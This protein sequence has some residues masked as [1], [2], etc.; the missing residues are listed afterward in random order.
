VEAWELPAP[1]S[2]PASDPVAVLSLHDT[3]TG[4]PQPVAPAAA[5][6]GEGAG[7]EPIRIYACG[8]TPYD[9]THL[10]HAHTFVALDLLHRTL[11]DGG[12]RVHLVQN[13]TDVDDPLFARARATGEPWQVIAHREERRF[14]RDMGALEVLPPTVYVAASEAI[15]E[16]RQLVAALRERG[17]AYPLA[18]DL[19]FDVSADPHLGS[20]CHL[21]G[22]QMR[23]LL[24][25]RGG[26]PDRPGKRS[27]LD[28]LLWQRSAPDEPVWPADWGA[29]RPGWHIECAAIAARH[30]GLPLDVQFGGRDLVYPHHELSAAHAGVVHGWPFARIFAHAGMVWL[31]GEKMSKSLGNL[32]FVSAL[33][34]EGVEAAAIRLM[35]L[36]HRWREDWE[37]TPA[38]L[39]VAQQRL[40][41]WRSQAARAGSLG[42]ALTEIRE[43]L[44]DDLDTPGA[45]AIVDGVTAGG[46]E[47]SGVTASLLGVR[48]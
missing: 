11:R 46:A 34:A 35:L 32:V 22:E 6:A 45:L 17:A 23:T 19:Y 43:R 28:P 12:H 10:G 39:A 21:D 42:S 4:R 24:A 7:A 1:A 27:P 33:L 29:G 37:Y 8:I 13:V 40:A 47:L 14:A 41:R 44:A 26:D 38:A 18:E 2:I 36:A 20:V 5:A 31:D 3:A 48:L 9:A 25:A 30:C 15:D 16:V